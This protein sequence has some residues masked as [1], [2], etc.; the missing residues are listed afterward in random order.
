MRRMSIVVLSGLILF[1]AAC[2]PPP[3]CQPPA[4]RAS[5]TCL[6]AR[7]SLRV[8]KPHPS[9]TRRSWSRMAGSCPWANGVRCR[10]RKAPFELI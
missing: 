2:A 9:K 3:K 10:P 1:I 7:G 8:T 4:V 6:K 5:A